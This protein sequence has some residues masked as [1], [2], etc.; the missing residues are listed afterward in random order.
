M[1]EP[2]VNEVSFEYNDKVIENVEVPSFFKKGH[3]TD[4]F[5]E[6]KEGI[7]PEEAEEEMIGIN[8]LEKEEKSVSFKVP[9]KQTSRIN[10]LKKYQV[11]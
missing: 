7:K 6:F 4:L 2:V 11:N 9:L 10:K 3:L 1:T 8:Y 5:I